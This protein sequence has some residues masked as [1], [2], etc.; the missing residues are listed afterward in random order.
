[1][2]WYNI[3]ALVLGC[4]G[5]SGGLVS[6]FTARAKR[7]GMQTDS[8]KKIIDEAQEERESLRRDKRELAERY[9]SRIKALEEKTEKLERRDAIKMRAISSA[10]R[11]K[12]PDNIS[13]CPVLKTLGEECEK[14]EGVCKIN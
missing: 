7:D 9:E 5:G 12:L 11:C 6:L 14:N 13:D 2:E 3:L 4:L 8:M 10:Y 1:M